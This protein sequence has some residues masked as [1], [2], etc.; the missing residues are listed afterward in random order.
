MGLS[1]EDIGINLTLVVVASLIGRITFIGSFLFLFLLIYLMD[2]RKHDGY[3][4]II[5]T[6]FSHGRLQE[7]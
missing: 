7:E 2:L 6:L 1:M 5:I 4:L 3:W